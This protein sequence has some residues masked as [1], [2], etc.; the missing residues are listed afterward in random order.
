MLDKLKLTANTVKREIKVYQRVLRDS[1][2]P[3]PAKA[4]LG[5]AIGY[6][7]LPI[8][9]IPDP[10]P[11]LGQLDDLLIVPGLI[12]AALKLIPAE[13]VED[14]RAQVKVE[15]ARMPDSPLV[16]TEWLAQHLNDTNLRIVDIRGHIIP[17]SEPP[18]HY[19]N[20][21]ADYVQS[22]IPGALF[23]DWV[24]EITDPADPRH[25]QIA[26]PERFAAVMSRLGIRPETFVVAYDDA[27]GMFAARL[28]WALKYYGHP[29]VAVLDGGWK[30]WT[31][32]GR[33]ITANVPAIAPAQFIAH[34]DPVI[35]RSGDQVASTLDTATRLVDLR[36]PEEFT[37]KSSRASR[38]GH[39][40]GAVNVPRP[41]FVASDGTLLPPD[42][43]RQKF[44]A[45][46]VDDSVP[47]IITYCNAGVSAS[48]GLLALH[49]AGFKNAAVYDGSWKDWGND[50]GRGIE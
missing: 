9:I 44:A 3:L 1:R 7:F 18:P 2:T 39:I 32:E 19:F 10:I 14:C 5:L 31:A 24:H 20:H 40:P 29:R 48:F 4:L 45:V 12:F 26:P 33:P 28:W 38:K 23:V 21:Q 15:E 37:G 41:A 50:E 6:F 34:P 46:G 27:D 36:S 35:Y 30:K 43:L 11:V 42:A 16:T 49:V 8:D 25:A 47:E 22:H 17:A 13:V